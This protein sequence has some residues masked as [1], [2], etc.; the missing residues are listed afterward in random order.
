MRCF[1]RSADEFLLRDDLD[2]ELFGTT[3][4]RLDKFLRMAAKMTQ[5]S[6]DSCRISTIENRNR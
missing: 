6:R 3:S 2:W 1:S 4:E 5:P